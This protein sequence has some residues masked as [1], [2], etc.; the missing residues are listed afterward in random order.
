ML[1]NENEFVPKRLPGG[2]VFKNK[3]IQL[4]KSKGVD[5]PSN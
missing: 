5:V 2:R 1:G 3:I 4:L